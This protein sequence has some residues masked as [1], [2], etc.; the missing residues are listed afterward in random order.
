MCVLQ[1]HATGGK[2]FAL[3][4]VSGISITNNGL[5]SMSVSRGSLE[6]RRDIP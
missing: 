1:L 6:R 5:I 2:E 3:V 4:N